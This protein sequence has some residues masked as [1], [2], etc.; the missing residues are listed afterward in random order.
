LPEKGSILTLRIVQELRAALSFSEKEHKDFGLNATAE[1]ITWNDKGA[2]EKE[3]KI[4]EEATKIIKDKLKELD[5]AEELT[6]T[7][8]SIWERFME[9]D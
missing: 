8:I 6:P 7:D 9:V 4:G 3:V 5:E 2:K 1:M